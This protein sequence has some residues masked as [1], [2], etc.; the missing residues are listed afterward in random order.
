MIKLVVI[1]EQLGERMSTT[2]YADEDETSTPAEKESIDLTRR[3]HELSA[4]NEGLSDY[5]RQG[6]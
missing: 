5:W 2:Y 1:A 6:R 3:S 4:V